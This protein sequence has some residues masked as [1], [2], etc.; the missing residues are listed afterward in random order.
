MVRCEAS[1]FYDGKE[2]GIVAEEI[3]I[4]V[5]GNQIEVVKRHFFCFKHIFLISPGGNPK[6]SWKHFVK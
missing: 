4:G 3:K 5:P 1:F 6:Y 2:T